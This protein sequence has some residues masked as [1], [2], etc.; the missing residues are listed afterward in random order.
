M[1]TVRTSPKV[2]TIDSPKWEG[3]KGVIWVVILFLIG[4]AILWIGAHEIS[5]L[6]DVRY[7]LYFGW[8]VDIPFQPWALWIYLPHDFIILFAAL[9]FRNWREAT[10]FY[11]TLVVQIA[12]AFPFFILVPIEP[13]YQNEMATGVWGTYGFE[14]IGMKNISQWNH[15]PSLHVSYV[16]VLGTVIGQRYGLWGWIVGMGWAVL[17]SATTMLVHEHHVICVVGGLLLYLFTMWTVFPWFKQ[18]CGLGIDGR[19]LTLLKQPSSS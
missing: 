4:F 3:R 12:I 1:S 19:D 2:W 7:P 11:A 16:F 14:M 9:M 10:P 15:M 6:R 17:V 8:E 13:G 5:D 18:K